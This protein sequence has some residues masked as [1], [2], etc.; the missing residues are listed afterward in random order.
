[1]A[2]DLF[3]SYSLSY[4]TCLVYLEGNLCV[5]KTTTLDQ[6]EKKHPDWAFLG[7]PMTYWRSAHGDV[8][9]ELYEQKDEC[10]YKIPALQ[11]WFAAP[12][13]MRQ[14]KI[15]NQIH[16]TSKSDTMI[17]KQIRPV[18][19]D[20]HALSACVVFPLAQLVLKKV[21]LNHVLNLMS[22]V[23]GC[24]VDNIIIL[25]NDYKT[26]L[27]RNRIRARKDEHITQHTIYVLSWL[28]YLLYTTSIYCKEHTRSQFLKDF[29]D[30][31]DCA[32]TELYQA[33]SALPVGDSETTT[34]SKFSTSNNRTSSVR[35][36]ETLFQL[37]KT[38]S[39]SKAKTL[40]KCT[41]LILGHV[42]DTIKKV[43][44]VL[45]NTLDVPVENV[46]ECV[47][48]AIH[49]CCDPQEF[50]NIEAE[51]FFDIKQNLSAL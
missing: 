10:K 2:T 14:E 7:E 32:N 45:L 51:Y 47:L 30:L 9:K 25:W 43:K 16:A 4:K 11:Q 20:R 38:E 31:E 33:L 12:L 36:N 39:L 40:D 1:M 17:M 5:G 22:T 15:Y 44:I 34:L 24:E 49:Q 28:Y 35:I 48:S 41:K 50:C 37:I 19:L 13:R 46:A 8:I 6:L 23:V 26:S 18:I 27:V 29:V 21:D 42:F 3:E